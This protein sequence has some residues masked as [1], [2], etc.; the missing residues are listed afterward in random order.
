MSGSCRS[1]ASGIC[2]WCSGW[3]RRSIGRGRVSTCRRCASSRPG[4][5]CGFVDERPLRDPQPALR[6]S[7]YLSK[8]LAKWRDDG[9]LEVSETV[10]AAGRALLNYV[11]RKLTARSGCTM[12]ALRNAR[13]V[14]AWREGL[15]PEHGLD[16]WS[17]VVAVCL[18]ERVPVPARA[19]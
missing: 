10:Q 2:T 6:V 13:V 7:S 17:F 9:T 19:P 11:S 8:Y 12:R 15:I 4:I 1:V 18:L 14:W 5:S 3:R 16:E